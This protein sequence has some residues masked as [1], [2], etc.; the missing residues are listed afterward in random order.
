MLVLAD[1]EVKHSH[2]HTR[3]RVIDNILCKKGPNGFYKVVVPEEVAKPMILE[4][5]ETYAH[6]GKKKVQ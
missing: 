4:I 3:Y 5:H 1:L 6:I 2:Q